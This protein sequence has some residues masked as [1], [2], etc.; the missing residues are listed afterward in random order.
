MTGKWETFRMC[1]HVPKKI[2]HFY[3]NTKTKAL[4]IIIIMKYNYFQEI[5]SKS[6]VF[7]HNHYHMV[8]NQIFKNL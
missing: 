3:F 1:I 8:I 7:R 6:H 2:C 5:L 4:Q